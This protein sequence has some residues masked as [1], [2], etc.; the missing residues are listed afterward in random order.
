MLQYITSCLYPLSLIHLLLKFSIIPFIS[1][2]SFTNIL[3]S[4]SFGS[5]S[6]SDTYTRLTLWYVIWRSSFSLFLTVCCSLSDTG[7]F[8]SLFYLIHFCYF[9]VPLLVFFI[10]HIHCV[11]IHSLFVIF[12]LIVHSKP[13]KFLYLINSSNSSF[14]L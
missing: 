14:K 8:G 3:F 13:N 6:I 4:F 10:I 12:Y 7:F 11:F 2:L 9:S 1:S 5:L